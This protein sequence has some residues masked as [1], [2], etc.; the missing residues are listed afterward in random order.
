VPIN[1][2]EDKAMYLANTIGC[3]VAQMP[4]TYLGLPIGTTRPVVEDF[5]PL[6]NRI[7]K[8]LMGLNK[9]LGYYGRLNYVNSILSA[10]P[11]FF[12]CTLK[13]SVKI[14]EQ[15]DKYRKHCL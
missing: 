11:T 6:L 13:I 1:I 7:E 9:L 2:D 15:V 8:C 14:F 4:F 12:M 5:Q 3:Q 10:L